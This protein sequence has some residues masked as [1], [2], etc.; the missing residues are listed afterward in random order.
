MKM[1]RCNMRE[2]IQLEK[3]QIMKQPERGFKSLAS[4]ER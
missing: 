2:N 3:L 4:P 1:G